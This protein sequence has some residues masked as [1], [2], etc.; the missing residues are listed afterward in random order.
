MGQAVR[1][2]ST[3][4]S[5]TDLT[6]VSLASHLTDECILQ[7]TKSFITE[8]NRHTWPRSQTSERGFMGR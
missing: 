5:R 2:A 3:P 4:S 1:K 8:L 6:L 7:K